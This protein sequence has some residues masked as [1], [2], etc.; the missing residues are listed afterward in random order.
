MKYYLITFSDYSETIGKQASKAAMM[1]D[2]RKYCR[3]WGLSETVKEIHEISESE[4]NSR[5]NK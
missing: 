1:K 2:A 5:L 3:M 4:Y